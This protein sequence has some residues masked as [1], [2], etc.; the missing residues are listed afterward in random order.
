MRRLLHFEVYIISYN[1]YNSYNN[2]Q[3][4]NNPYHQSLHLY[5]QFVIFNP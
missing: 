5:I 2:Q 4:L 1:D 3:A